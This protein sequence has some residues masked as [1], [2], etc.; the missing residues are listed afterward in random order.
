MCRQSVRG[1]GGWE[2]VCNKCDGQA[3]V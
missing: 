2:F 1:E 3:A